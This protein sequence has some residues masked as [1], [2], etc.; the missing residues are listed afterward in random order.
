MARCLRSRRWRNP[1][2]ELLVH[3]RTENVGSDVLNLNIL[4]KVDRQIAAF[5]APCSQLLRSAPLAPCR[6]VPRLPRF[7]GQGGH[8]ILM[9]TRDDI[10]GKRREALRYNKLEK[11]LGRNAEARAQTM[12]ENSKQWQGKV[13]EGRFP[14]LRHLG[15]SSKSAIF[16]TERRDGERIVNAAIKLIASS[17]KEDD[18]QLARWQQ[19]AQLS[20]PHLL[21]LFESGRCEVAGQ[22]FL[23]VVTEYAAEN[24]GEVLPER[25][26]MPAEARGMLESVLEVLGYIHALKLVHGNLKPG[27]I[28]AN[29]D[30]LKLSSD[31]LRR[32]GDSADHQDAAN[33]YSPPE[34]IRGIISAPDTLSAASDVWSLGMLLVEALTQTL[35]AGRAGAPGYFVLPSALPEPFL[36]IVCH[37]LVRPP[38][39][40]WTITQISARLQQSARTRPTQQVSRS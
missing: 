14:L 8:L 23:Y 33:V 37:C 24:L 17:A 21:G 12:L 38:R 35:P 6:D 7:G 39:D 15:A 4:V 31:D 27:N 22:N 9:G 28:M 34:N 3:F 32:A 10:R 18:L 30:Q 36:D 40:R 11:G 20:H 13:V 1:R 25:A 16:Q 5:F 26:L 19:T 29:G 2:S